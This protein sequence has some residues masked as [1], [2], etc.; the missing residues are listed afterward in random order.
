MIHIETMKF[1]QN[2]WSLP[3]TLFSLQTSDLANHLISF[4]I[5]VRTARQC[6]RGQN[7][8]DTVRYPHLGEN[9]QLR[10]PAI[11]K[12][13]KDVNNMYKQYTGS[14]YSYLA[15]VNSKNTLQLRRR[16]L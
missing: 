11:S 10:Y 14:S 2:H 13:S 7:F 8:S 9:I 6:A 4:I 12:S 3:Y 5:S 16:V 15:P 1:W